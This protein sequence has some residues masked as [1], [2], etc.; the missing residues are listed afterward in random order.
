MAKI[1]FTRQAISDI[2]E[3]AAY[4]SLDS[5]FYAKMQVS[6][7]FARALS[8][9]N[10]PEI[11]RVVPELNIKSVREVIEGNYRI[12]YKIENT[13]IIYIITVHHSSRQLKRTILKRKIKH[14]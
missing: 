9:E 2:E 3:I 14:G 8:L 7:I 11:G 1:E 5:V 12:I 10:H 6:K 4:I 13:K